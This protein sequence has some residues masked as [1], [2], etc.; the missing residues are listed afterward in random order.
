MKNKIIIKA[1]EEIAEEQ[2]KYIVLM[3]S[4]YPFN[5]KLTDKKL[6][7]DSVEKYNFNK[8]FRAKIEDFNFFGLNQKVDGLTINL[9]R[10]FQLVVLSKLLEKNLLPLSEIK[11]ISFDGYG[12]NYRSWNEVKNLFLYNEED[13]SIISKKYV[14]GITNFDLSDVLNR[15]ATSNAPVYNLTGFVLNHIDKL[16]NNHINFIHDFFIIFHTS[17]SIFRF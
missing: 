12:R 2:G 7:E 13:I 16:K 9:S 3:K 10:E 6:Y 17:N 1:I 8:V 4:S 5:Y 11:K 15:I 14:S